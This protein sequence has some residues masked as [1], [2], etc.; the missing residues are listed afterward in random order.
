MEDEFAKAMRVAV[1]EG[2][3]EMK[4]GSISIEK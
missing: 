3:V 2:T 1:S 4:Q